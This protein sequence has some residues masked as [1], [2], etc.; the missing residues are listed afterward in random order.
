MNTSETTTENDQQADAQKVREPYTPPTIEMFPPMA[1]WLTDKLAK[2]TPPGYALSPVA[3]SQPA[4]RFY[5]PI[6][7][8]RESLSP[9]RSMRATLP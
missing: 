1:E 5:G 6:A 2:Y 3:A 9:V 8:V 4:P 7:R